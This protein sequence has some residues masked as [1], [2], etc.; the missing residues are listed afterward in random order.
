MPSTS[1]WYKRPAQQSGS[2]S[3]LDDLD[4]GK[5]RENDGKFDDD[6][7]NFGSSDVRINSSDDDGF[8]R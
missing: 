5:Y 4:F 7:D 8:G 6:E 3:N 2:G 1:M